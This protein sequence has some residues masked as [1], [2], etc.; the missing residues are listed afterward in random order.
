MQALIGTIYDAATEPALWNGAIAEL[1]RKTGARSG[2]FYD[3]HDATRQSRV[4]GAE[5]FDPYYVNR[6]E[7]Y[8]GALDPWHRCGRTRMVGSIDQTAGMLSAAELRRTEFYQDHLRPQGVFYAMGGPVERASGR[9]AI[10]GIQCGYENGPFAPEAQA[11]VTALMPHFRRAYGMQ[12]TLAGIFRQVAEFEAALHVLGQPVLVV[13]CDAFLWFANAAGEELLRRGDV[14]SR[15][16]GRL[17][18]AHRDDAAAFA[19]ALAPVPRRS[20]GDGT[21]MLRRA[22]GATPCRIRIMPLR[23]GNRAEWSGR[24]ALLVEARPSR[25]G[26]RALALAFRLSAAELRLWEELMA[27]R[28]LSA[29][30]ERS[31]VSIHTVRVQLAGLFRKTGANR[32]AD[33]VRLGL[34]LA[35]QGR[36]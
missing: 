21:M 24:I 22:G 20:D 1:V 27:G 19:Q 10:F 16:R 9:M 29:I 18:V 32:Q 34:D 2:I 15:S 28:T 8:Y 6:Y 14:L 7:Q 13:D 30:A 23:S 11:I 12:Q 4:L 36:N 3:H 17:H 31:H 25:R 33:L 26:T 35:G 5:G